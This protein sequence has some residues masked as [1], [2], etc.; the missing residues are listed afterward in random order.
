LGQLFDTPTPPARAGP[1]TE[2]ILVGC[3]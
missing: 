1:E 2:V 3:G